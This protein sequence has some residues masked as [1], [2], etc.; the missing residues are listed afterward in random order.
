MAPRSLEDLVLW[1]A[2]RE[3]AAEV[4]RQ[5]GTRRFDDDPHLR[6]E[7]RTTARTIMASIAAGYGADEATCLARGFDRAAQ[8]VANLSSLLHLTIDLRLLD[9]P[10]AARLLTRSLELSHLIRGWQRAIREHE[11]ARA[12]TIN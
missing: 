10:K 9:Q 4:Y 3:I 7:L 1:Q 11:A 8:A 5:T 2:A 12:R 6:N